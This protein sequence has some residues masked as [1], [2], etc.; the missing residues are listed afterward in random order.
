M[1]EHF[2]ETAQQ[3]AEVDQEGR[4]E[5]SCMTSG[6]RIPPNPDRV[7]PQISSPDPVVDQ[8]GV[9][10]SPNACVQCVRTVP[11]WPVQPRAQ[12]GFAEDISF[13]QGFQF[14]ER[15]LPCGGK[16]NRWVDAML[17]RTGFVAPGHVVESTTGTL[18][19]PAPTQA[20]S[21]TLP[22]FLHSIA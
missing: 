11:G 19:T 20:V 12:P 7:E 4:H 21:A 13:P 8:K 6:N 3:F 17:G 15:S 2:A 10:P 9:N 18:I 1:C 14:D 22:T 5:G 16:T